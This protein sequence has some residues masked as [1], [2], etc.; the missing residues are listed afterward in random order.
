MKFKAKILILALSCGIT[1]TGCSNQNEYNGIKYKVE[2]DNTL[3]KNDEIYMSLY[4]DNEAIVEFL[5]SK[6]L[7]PKT[8]TEFRIS[9]P[10]DKI[11]I[12]VY[13]G[14]INGKN[15]YR[16]QNNEMKAENSKEEL[17]DEVY[18]IADGKVEKVSKESVDM[19]GFDGNNDGKI[20]DKLYDIMPSPK[21]FDVKID[22]S[23]EI[24]NGKVRFNIKTNLPNNTELMVGLTSMNGDYKG[25][26][27][28]LVKDGKAQTEWFSDKGEPIKNGKYELSTS[29]SMPVLQT[30]E[31]QKIVGKN[32]E[33]MKGNLVQKSSI[34]NSFYISKESTIEL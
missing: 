25:Q 23:K 31:V 24:E 17:S 3:I 16:V 4:K 34:D 9:G 29:M 26:T 13:N 30:E 5:N 22:E 12:R 1:L 6:D 20:D 11:T 15:A 21:A 18:T 14:K 33:Y 27:K 10:S 2:D 28:T 8:T 19:Y 7:L 32:G